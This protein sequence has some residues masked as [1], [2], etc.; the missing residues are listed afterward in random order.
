MDENSSTTKSGET[1]MTPD[2][3]IAQLA[4]MRHL[5]RAIA[6]QANDGRYERGDARNAFYVVASN[7]ILYHCIVHAAMLRA[8]VCTEETNQIVGETLV[9][10]RDL[11]LQDQFWGGARRHLFLD[12]WCAFED[13][14]RVLY[15][16]I[17]PQ[18]QRD[19]DKKRN[20]HVGIP[21][22][23]SRIADVVQFSS[24]ES[25]VPGHV[26]LVEFLGSTRNTIHSNSFYRGKYRV[27]QF[28]AQTKLELV[29]GAPTDFLSLAKI[30]RMIE[31]LVEAMSYLR[32]GLA[33]FPRIET[34][35]WVAD[36]TTTHTTS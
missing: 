34:P 26:A 24:G 18:Q 33:S 20:G 3:H 16:N 6:L 27:L 32:R 7:S 15:E 28:D 11:D 14:I 4:K 19:E 36:N 9:F 13:T 1:H 17:V 23:W 29:D 22:V 5:A 31:G 12:V 21:T 30:P 2:Q 25:K 8:S 35:S 10:M